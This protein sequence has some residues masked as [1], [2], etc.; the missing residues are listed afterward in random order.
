[1]E[2]GLFFE[3][4]FEGAVLGTAHFHLSCTVTVSY[5]CTVTAV[6]IIL[7]A[8]QVFEQQMLAGDSAVLQ[9]WV[10][11]S[12]TS[13]TQ[14]NP[15]A[16]A[17]WSLSCFFVSASM[18]DWLKGMFPFVSSRIGLLEPVSVLLLPSYML[19]Q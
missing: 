11:L 7:Y 9:D 17:I 19:G 6:Q 1:M 18:N 12:V 5:S 13:F 16:T 10:L 15:L 3:V 8:S 2:A 4:V 14:R